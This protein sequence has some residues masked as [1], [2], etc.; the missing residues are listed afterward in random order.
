MSNWT[1]HL[2]QGVP[3]VLLLVYDQFVSVSLRKMDKAAAVSAGVNTESPDRPQRDVRRDGESAVLHEGKRY[4]TGLMLSSARWT[5]YRG[6]Y[7]SV[8]LSCVLHLPLNSACLEGIVRYLQKL[9]LCSDGTLFLFVSVWLGVTD[10]KL[11]CSCT[12][13]MVYVTVFRNVHWLALSVSNTLIMR[14][15]GCKNDA[16]EIVFCWCHN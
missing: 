16:C 9:C 12:H 7:V 3:S 6:C 8:G 14:W 15:N 10:G 4:W 1:D 13:W 2:K 11:A 5:T